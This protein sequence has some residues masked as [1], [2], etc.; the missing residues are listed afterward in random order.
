[1]Y[2]VSYTGL[3]KR[4][5]YDEIVALLETDQTKIKYPNRVASQIMNSPFMKQVDVETLMDLQNQQDRMSKQKLKELVL[6]EIAKQTAT[7][8]V[9]LRA[10]G[11]PE[12]MDAVLEQVSAIRASLENKDVD[13]RDA[14]AEV[15]EMLDSATQTEQAKKRSMANL[16]A[17]SLRDMHQ[18]YQPR[19]HEMA[20][21]ASV[22]TLVSTADGGTQTIWRP[23]E[24]LE[25]H[26]K[27]TAELQRQLVEAGRREQAASHMTKE[28]IEHFE[29][30]QKLKQHAQEQQAAHENVA[31]EV[32]KRVPRVIQ[33]GSAG[34][35]WDVLQ[36]RAVD[37]AQVKT[38]TVDSEMIQKVSKREQE[39]GKVGNRKQRRK[40][41]EAMI[42]ALE[43]P[44]PSPAPSP[45]ANRRLGSLALPESGPPTTLAPLVGPVAVRRQP[46]S[47]PVEIKG[48]Q[49][50]KTRWS[51]S[52]S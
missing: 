37:T 41:N 52:H 16:T 10:G 30:L 42:I 6:Q 36:Q 48:K 44:A 1:M 4:G 34:S 39:G 23:E 12:R 51:R 9:E 35:S 33:P 17:S 8:Y 18:A 29:N 45:A 20:Q 46:D 24:E 43:P 32:R 47:T 7:P 22:Q 49:R 14:R 27:K 11:S 21:A 5:T 40:D 2:Q 50:R 38:G 19:A 3:Q 25:S 31:K 26:S 15:S 13:M 28:L